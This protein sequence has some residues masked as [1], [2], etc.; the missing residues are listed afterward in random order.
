M[1]AAAS[2]ALTGQPRRCVYMIGI[3]DTLSKYDA[4]SRAAQVRVQYGLC[5]VRVLIPLPLPQSLLFCDLA[6]G[7]AASTPII[8]KM[9]PLINN[10]QIINHY[11][12]PLSHSR[13]SRVV[14]GL[15]AGEAR[16]RRRDL[17]RS[18]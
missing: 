5:T 11:S 18:A 6:V 13:L 9:K 4:K 16:R 14:A 2:E 12:L 1:A 7:G 17:Y 3:I 15:Q 8:Y 10:V